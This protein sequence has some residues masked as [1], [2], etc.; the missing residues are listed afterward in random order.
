MENEFEEKLISVNILTPVDGGLQRKKRVIF[1][2][3][4]FNNDIKIIN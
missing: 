4:Q 2:K 1:V 3:K